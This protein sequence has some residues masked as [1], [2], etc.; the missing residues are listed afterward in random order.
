MLALLIEHESQSIDA[1]CE[2]L[3]AEY[4]SNR[5]T[6]HDLVFDQDRLRKEY[7]SF[8]NPAGPS[9][10]A[11]IAEPVL[12]SALAPGGQLPRPSVGQQLRA[13]TERMMSL[14]N[15]RDLDARFAR[16]TPAE[17]SIQVKKLDMLYRELLRS[18]D[19]PFLERIRKSKEPPR[20]L[21]AMDLH[22]RVTRGML[23]AFTAFAQ[24]M[25]SSSARIRVAEG[26]AA[27]RRWQLGHAG[28]WP[29][30]LESAAKEAGLP[31]VPVDP[32]DG[33]PI[34]FAVVQGQPTVYAIGQDG[35]DDGGRIDNARTPD[36]GD[37]LLRLPKP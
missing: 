35:R 23:P 1:Y 6:L 12:I 2:G 24:S 14:K 36:S 18:A 9:I 3:R 10:V 20:D 26:L 11:E 4:L 28:E 7:E 29:P 8:G 33:R 25:A 13:L 15:I 30:S 17:L 37:V 32:Y 34:R 19:A 5:A 21:D 31:S 16:T 27:V 22:A